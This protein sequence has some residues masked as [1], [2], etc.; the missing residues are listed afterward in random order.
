MSS[1][2]YTTE[3]SKKQAATT[4]TITTPTIPTDSKVNYVYPKLSLNTTG[5]TVGQKCFQMLIEKNHVH[6]WENASDD[7]ADIILAH[8]DQDKEYYRAHSHQM[9]NRVPGMKAL[10]EKKPS[11]FFL[12]EFRDSFPEEF[13]FVPR[14]FLIPEERNEFEAYFRLNKNKIFIA[15]PSSG[16]HGDGIKLI[17]KYDDLLATSYHKESSDL[18]IQEYI[19]KPL[20][21]DKKKFDLRVFVTITSVKP[22]VAF[23]NE[24]GLAR[25]CTEDYEEPTNE[26]FNNGYMHLTNYALNKNNPKYNFTEETTEMHN[27]SKRSFASLWKSIQAMGHDT[28][29]IFEDIKDT[30]KKILI[31]LRPQIELCYEAAYKG[32]P[33][34]KNYH[35]LGVDI[36]ID[37]NLKPWFIEINANPSLNVMFELEN[38]ETQEKLKSQLSPIDYYVKSRVA[39]EAILMAILDPVE[40]AKIKRFGSYIA[41]MKNEC[42]MQNQMRIYGEM[43]TIFRNMRDA[44][45]TD[46]V[47]SIDEFKNLALLKGMTNIDVRHSDYEKIY[48]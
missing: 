38:K 48:R 22:F 40:Q 27:G 44:S 4:T 8:I 35:I 20:L 9:M 45:N 39:E 47:L 2:S 25:F 11:G 1:S 13:S 3:K 5:A 37:E 23:I 28:N 19:D 16:K 43:G 26:N 7:A 21:V 17:K 10:C 6:G 14:T 29:K 18:V 33:S 24:E 12:N 30:M 46:E 41:L 36:M 32:K 34:G 15:K 31:A 42:E